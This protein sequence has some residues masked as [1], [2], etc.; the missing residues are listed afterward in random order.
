M[1]KDSKLD[2]YY[3]GIN[4][5]YAHKPHM[6]D[7]VSALGG[8]KSVESKAIP[9]AAVV[10][11]KNKTVEL[12]MNNEFFSGLTD[13]EK[14]GVLTHEFHHVLLSHLHE[15]SNTEKWPQANIL[16]LAH[17]VVI[18]DY[19]ELAGYELPEDRISGE[20]FNDFFAYDTTDEAYQKLLKNAEE[21]PAERDS[22]SDNSAGGESSDN[23]S[24][25]KGSSKG[26][27]GQPAD[28]SIC[29]GPLAEGEDGEYRPLTPEEFE[30]LAEALKNAAIAKIKEVKTPDP[31]ELPT[32]QQISEGDQAMA[33]ALNDD[34]QVYSKGAGLDGSE[35][36]QI[37]SDKRL[38]MNW[39][40]IL[41]MVNKAIGKDGSMQARGAVNWAHR[42]RATLGIPNVILPSVGAPVGEGIG[43]GTAPE[44]LLALDFSGSVPRSMTSIMASL[45]K[46]I[47]TDKI[48]PKCITFSTYAVDFDHQADRNSTAS[49]GTDFSS[50][51]KVA[52]AMA[53]NN[54]GV[55]P[56]VICM[57]DGEANFSSITPKVNE[58]NEKWIW[59]DITTNDDTKAFRNLSTSYSLMSNQKNKVAIPYDLTQVR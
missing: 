15:Q 20:K 59:V 58:L 43:A 34:S 9:T 26:G 8:P 6:A 32:E 25:A 46:S 5:L 57:T 7:Y 39:V 21:N 31:Q 4:W 18:N 30:E 35:M 12:H 10:L 3:A 40:N 42:R 29:S 50:V 54:R 45:A 48:K 16:E 38:N 41:R 47:P 13:G 56:H 51:A 44:V 11:T 17:E 52:E 55:Y 24:G 2:E 1:A 22:G 14:A 19:L 27:G 49:G 53:A 28:S 37:L 23:N 33:D 36:E